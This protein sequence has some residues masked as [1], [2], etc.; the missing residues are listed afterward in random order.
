[1]RTLS[2]LWHEH[3]LASVVF[4]AALG[5][6]VFFAVRIV[7]LSLYWHAY[8]SDPRHIDQPLEP[9]MTVGYVAHSYDVPPDRLADVVGLQHGERRRQGRPLT[10]RDIADDRGITFDAL[11][12]EF[13]AALERL[14]EARPHER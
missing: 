10:L 13:A 14:R 9:W 7:V 6:A 1:M 3:R 2:R 8:W 12:A 5:V 11:N 4:L